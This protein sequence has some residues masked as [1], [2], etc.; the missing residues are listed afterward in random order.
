MGFVPML[1][2]LGSSTG[3]VEAVVASN[4]SIRHLLVLNEPNH[5]KQAWATPQEAATRWPAW[6]KFA[7]EHKLLLVGPQLAYGADMEE[8][9]TP[10]QWMDA[11]LAAFREQHHRE[12]TLHAIGYHYYGSDGHGLCSSGQL[13]AVKKY[14]KPIWLTEFAH[15]H[16]ASVEEQK[17]WMRR[18]VAHCERDP[19][20][21]RY[22]W[23]I[24]RAANHPHL[25]LLDADGALTE[26]GRY[27]ASLPRAQAEGEGGAPAAAEADGEGGAPAEA[28]P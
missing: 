16:A 23:F 6:E 20:V 26:L 28:I 11:F 25:A 14:G 24:A 2:N 5:R 18:T 12:P 15:Y 27:Y 22:S 7:E 19:D 17:S 10:V 3:E 1:W 8:Y 13:T 4:P 9:T 21:E